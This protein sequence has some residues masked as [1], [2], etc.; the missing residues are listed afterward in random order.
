MIDHSEGNKLGGCSNA[1]RSARMASRNEKDRMKI[2][3][4]RMSRVLLTNGS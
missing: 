2:V 1:R 3:D 4:V